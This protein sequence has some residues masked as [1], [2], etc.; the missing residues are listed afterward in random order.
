MVLSSGDQRM[1]V[2][3]DV[4]HCP[5]QLTHSEWEFFWDVDKDLAVR[6]REAMLREAEAPGTALLPAHF[7]GMQAG[8]LVA[9]AGTRRWVLG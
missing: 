4:L 2:L 8:R 7:P 5:A 6:T 1:I 9:A 3:G